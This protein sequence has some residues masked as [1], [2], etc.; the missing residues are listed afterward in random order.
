MITLTQKQ[1]AQLTGKRRAKYN[2][3][4]TEYRGVMY[5]S[6]AEAD[7][8]AE[9][10]LRKRAGYICDWARQVPFYLFAHGQLIGKII[11]DFAALEHSGSYEY[12]E[13]KGVETALYRWKLKHLKVQHPG[14]KLTVIKRGKPC[15]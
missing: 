1:A 12:F 15:K 6:K 5:D 3:K 8:A 2:A 9:L 4:R 13:V 7:F 14:L 10:D 11:L